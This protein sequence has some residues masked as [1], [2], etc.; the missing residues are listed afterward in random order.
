[1]WGQMPPILLS[2]H[3]PIYLSVHPFFCSIRLSRA[4]QPGAAPLGSEA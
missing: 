4:W 2:V 1:M 3:P